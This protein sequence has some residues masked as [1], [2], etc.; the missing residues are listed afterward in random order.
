MTASGIAGAYGDL[1]V[2][3]VMVGIGSDHSFFD[4]FA[5]AR[6][7]LLPNDHTASQPASSCK[8][9]ANF[10]ADQ[11]GCKVWRVRIFLAEP[12]IYAG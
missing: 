6:K 7:T 2:R 11:H 1:T 4:P 10:D 3:D 9:S 5:Q 12:L 8:T